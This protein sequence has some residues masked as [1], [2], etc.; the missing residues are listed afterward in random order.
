MSTD[1][2]M[3]SGQKL[4]VSRIFQTLAYQEKRNFQG[5]DFNEKKEIKKMS[6]G[7]I[8]LAESYKPL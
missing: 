1:L 4:E 5:I 7:K 8:G 3:G 6:K 2:M